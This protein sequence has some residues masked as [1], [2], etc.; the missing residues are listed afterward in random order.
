MKYFIFSLTLMFSI[1]SFSN[2]EVNT[3]KIYL[4]SCHNY[5]DSV[6]Y[7]YQS[8]INH[9]FQIIANSMTNYPYLS[10]CA[11][12]SRTRVDFSFT[13]CI[14]INFQ[15]I[16]RELDENVYVSY[17]SNFGDKLSYSYIS[18]VNNNY[19]RISRVIR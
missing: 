4:S 12:Y 10:H 16:V 19:H 9:N 1:S 8:C 6:S 2:T 14:N 13:S 18:C 15:K 3:D 11:N 7:A 5:G 17:C